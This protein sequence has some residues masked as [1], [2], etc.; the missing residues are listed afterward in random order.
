MHVSAKESGEVGLGGL[1]PLGFGFAGSAHRFREG[2]P[3]V[4]A[5]DLHEEVVA[6]F[7]AVG[8]AGEELSGVVP[9]ASLVDRSERGTVPF[10]AMDQRVDAP[11]AEFFGGEGV[12]EVDPVVPLEVGFEGLEVV[13]EEPP[14]AGDSPGS[15]P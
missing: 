4:F 14:E 7:E 6:N 10:K 15:I 2:G 11:T 8:D 9:A 5:V 3:H 12:G 13:G 1:C